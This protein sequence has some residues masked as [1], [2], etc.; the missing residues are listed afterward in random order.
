MTDRV[1][2]YAE[3][4][5]SGGG[6]HGEL[7][8]LACRR[9]V[10]D[11]RRIGDTD[12]V[13]WFDPD[14]AQRVIDYFETLTV[15]EGFGRRRVTLRD[16]QAFDLGCLF[17]W[18]KP[19]DDFNESYRRF[20]TMYASMARQQGKSFLNGGL[21]T[22]IAGFSGY[23]HGKLF[24]AAT[25]KRQSRIVWEEMSKF[26]E[27][28]PMLAEF[29][30]VKDYKNLI[31][32]INTKCTIEALSKEAGLDDG[33]RPIFAS[34]D[35]LH[36]MKDNSVYKALDNGTRDLMESLI[37]MITTRGF[38]V[39]SFA[40]EM[41]SYAVNILKGAVTADEFFADIYALDDDDDPF[42]ESVW[43]KANPRLAA[44]ERGMNRLR[45]D[46]AKAKT[47]GGS[48]LRDF[49]TKSMNVWV[50]R[51]ENS[52]V[53][54]KAWK[55]AKS[56]RTLDDFRGERCWAGVDLSSGGDLTTI[57]L[58]FEDGGGIYEWSHSFMPRGR[59]SEHIQTDIAPYDL[60]ERSGLI[61]VTGGES[62]FRNDYKFVVAKL[63]EVV[64]E[65]DLDLQAVGYDPHNADSF[66]SDLEQFGV[67]L[68]KVVQSAKSLNDATVDM[69]LLVKSGMFAYDQA[70]EL[71]AWSFA[72]AKLV[73]NSF[74][75]VKV[76]KNDSRFKRID[77]V[78]ACIDAHFA[79]LVQRDAEVIDVD[80]E[81]R[82][83]LAM[84][85][86]S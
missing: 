23:S 39:N 47:M 78:D 21:G 74:G 20:R 55:N 15:I 63:A 19:G 18:R 27:A 82:D 53:D 40:Y 28:D 29:F 72:N 25:K 49:L 33:F 67:P 3:F 17:G 77:P 45:E 22:Y 12:F 42:D 30:D 31:T 86:W 80:Q 13:Y 41:D 81:M 4:V 66:T 65:Y 50:T 1:T 73:S 38:D 26:I 60:W 69:Q 6:V 56:K 5:A 85:G 7:H 43:I 46:A 10:D 64:D 58:E 79:Y 35:E 34:L 75:E 59:L 61:T 24:T 54:P 51:T 32:A 71:M 52:F 76:D 57:S 14:E 2:A 48:E 11:L 16:D 44:T 8:R 62:D 36:Q 83:Y 9:H 70:N 84:A 68:I 37:S